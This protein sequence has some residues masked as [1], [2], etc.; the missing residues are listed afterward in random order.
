VKSTTDA[1]T[2]PKVT[3]VTLVDPITSL[4]LAVKA[5]VTEVVEIRLKPELSSALAELD[6]LIEELKSALQGAGAHAVFRGRKAGD[7]AVFVMFIGWDSV[8]ASS[9]NHSS[10]GF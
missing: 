2:V 10:F 1:G 6:A 3:F 4:E 8:Q 7:E 9:H 5:P